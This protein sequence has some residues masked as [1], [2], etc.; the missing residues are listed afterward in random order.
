MS[1]Y[2][3]SGARRLKRLIC[4]KYYTVLKWESRFNY[5]IDAAKITDYIRKQ[6]K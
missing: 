2:T 6:Y 3:K 5:K 4:F 1:F